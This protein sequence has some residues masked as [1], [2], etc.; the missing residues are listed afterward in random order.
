MK[1]KEEYDQHLLQFYAETFRSFALKNGLSSGRYQSHEAEGFTNEA[2]KQ[3]GSAIN[4]GIA[5]ELLSNLKQKN[6][7]VDDCIDNYPTMFWKTAEGPVE[8]KELAMRNVRSKTDMLVEKIRNKN[9]LEASEVEDSLK[10]IIESAKK[11]AFKDINTSGII[12]EEFINNLQRVV[13]HLKEE[14]INQ[15]FMQAYQEKLDADLATINSSFINVFI[16]EMNKQEKID[17]F[18]FIH[19][20]IQASVRDLSKDDSLKNI[21]NSTLKM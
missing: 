8:L 16:E 7:T 11:I 12:L 5:L 4:S 6:T 2:L 21:S 20:V 19:H 1:T 10:N 17:S 18:S 14:P 15:K 3:Y 13:S 9:P